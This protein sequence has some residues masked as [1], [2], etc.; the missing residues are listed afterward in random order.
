MKIKFISFFSILCLTN[1][2]FAD[3]G[4]VTVAKTPAKV[5]SIYSGVGPIYVT[6]STT[7]MIGCNG[8][9]AGYLQPTWASAMPN[10]EVNDS[11]GSRMM[12][13][14][15]T[16]KTMGAPVTVNYRLN[17]NGT[18]WNKCAISGITLSQ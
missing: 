16:A 11:E 14:L 7:E 5:T 9:N 6:F 15:L 13:V 3:F 10:G 12:S 18:G 4:P 2:V 1:T 8:N 17:S